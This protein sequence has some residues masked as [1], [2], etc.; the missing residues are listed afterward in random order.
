VSDSVRPH[1]W[2]PTRLPRPWDSPGKN[3]GM[4]CHFLLQTIFILKPKP[5]HGSLKLKPI[6]N[7]NKAPN[8]RLR[9]KKVTTYQIHTVSTWQRLVA[10]STS[11]FFFKYYHFLSKFTLPEPSISWIPVKSES[12]LNNNEELMGIQITSR[13]VAH[14]ACHSDVL[15]QE[16]ALL[17]YKLLIKFLFVTYS[18]VWAFWRISLLFSSYLAFI[19]N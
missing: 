19:H 3:R 12:K 4:G 2:Q 17:F 6:M 15:L 16:H 9:Y 14:Y 18:I 7:P 8:S 11:F 1:R 13:A 5:S 10:A